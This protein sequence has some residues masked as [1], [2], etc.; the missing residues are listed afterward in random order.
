MGTRVGIG[1][2]TGFGS[3]SGGTRSIWERER[4]SA[5]T[6]PGSRVWERDRVWERRGTRPPSQW[7]QVVTFF[8]NLNAFDRHNSLK[9]RTPQQPAYLR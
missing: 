2:G 7:E 3:L 6:N 8:Q 9:F 5:I 1:F 4:V